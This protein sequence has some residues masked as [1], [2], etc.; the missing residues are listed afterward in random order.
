MRDLLKIITID[1]CGSL[2]KY[3][4]YYYY[5]YNFYKWKWSSLGLQWYTGVP[6]HCDIFCHDINIVYWKSYC[7]IYDTFTYIYIYAS[8]NMGKHCL[9]LVLTPFPL[10]SPYALRFA[11]QTDKKNPCWAVLVVSA[12]LNIM[13]NACV[14]Q[15]GFVSCTDFCAHEQDTSSLLL[16]NVLYHVSYRGKTYRCRPPSGSARDAVSIPREFDN[17]KRASRMSPSFTAATLD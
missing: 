4:Y 5:E 7:D 17:L 8:T 12:I 14:L 3:Y 13:L 1:E 10:F 16:C 9:Q 11:E 2:F 15:L 6:V